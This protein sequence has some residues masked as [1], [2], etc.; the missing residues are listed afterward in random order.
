MTKCKNCVHFDAERH[1]CTYM[2]AEEPVTD[3][4]LSCTVGKTK[5]QLRAAQERVDD[6]PGGWEDC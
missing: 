6:N 4:E 5:E 3:D 2:E 1:V